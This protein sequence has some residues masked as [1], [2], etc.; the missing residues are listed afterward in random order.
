MLAYSIR[1]F[2]LAIPIIIGLSV[3]I[4][5]LLHVQDRTPLSIISGAEQLT[6]DERMQLTQY[7]HLDDNYLVQY[8][9]F[10]QRV[11]TGDMGISSVSGKS[12]LQEF[13][14]KLPATLELSLSALIIALLFGIPIGITAAFH[15]DKFID[16]S[17]RSFSIVFYSMPVFWF[18][19][20]L[21][22]IFAL[23]L[24]LTPVASRIN[25]IFDIPQ[26]T[27]FILIDVLISDASYKWHAFQDALLHLALPIFSLAIIPTALVT[28]FVRNGMIEVLN[29]DYIRTA[30]STGVPFF[31][32]LIRHCLKNALIPL[33]A[34]FGLLVNI[35]ITGGIVVE[36]IFVWPGIGAWLIDSVNKQDF[37]VVQALGL[38]TCIAIVLANTFF[39]I[40]YAWINPRERD[41]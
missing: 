5:S 39:Q 36:S 14:L 27:G 15:T 12:I 31:R 4:F 19:Y 13:L 8:L 18:S 22:F 10:M 40:L 6:A 34:M 21:I 11:F 35:L 20:L 1:K 30:R 9:H 29:S 37:V 25:L 41:F 16:K 23:Q 17:V 33:L 3:I 2:L 38:F 26:V 32:L 7:Y 24:K 28:R